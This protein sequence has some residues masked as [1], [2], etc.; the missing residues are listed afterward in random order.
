MLEPGEIHDGDAPVAG[1]FTYLT[2]YLDEQWL[3]K[4][5]Q[6]LY[7]TTPDSY[8]LHFSRTLSR[9]PQLVRA[10][11][12]TFNALHTEELRI[13][14]QSTMDHLSQLTT[15]CHWRKRASPS[16]IQSAAIAH[17]ARDYLHAHM[18]D[19]IGLSDLA[20]ETERIVLPLTRSFKREFHLAPHAWLIQ[21]RLA[22]ARRDAG[23]GSA[24]G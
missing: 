17:R 20:R 7:D 8:S 15:H 2:F 24:A 5:L 6:G 1:G 9:E 3:T 11:G 10:I 18:G 22:K 14:Q 21:L 13:V 4:T 12:E 23:E 19:N 16:Q